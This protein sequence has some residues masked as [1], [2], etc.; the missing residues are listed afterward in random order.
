MLGL[1]PPRRGWSFPSY[2]GSPGRP[3][4]STHFAERNGAFCMDTLSRRYNP[5]TARTNPPFMIVVWFKNGYR[6]RPTSNSLTGHRERLIWT[7]SRKREVRW[8][9]QCSKPGLSSLPEI[10]MSYGPSCQT[11]GMKLL[12]L[13]VTFDPWHDKWNQRSK[14]K[15]SG[16]LIKWVN[17]CK[18]LF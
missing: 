10:A 13:R 7:P 2:R 4:L 17:F 14:Q 16:I 15:G 6:G 18:R 12:R 5:F 8:K 1:D 3:A 11:C 9:G